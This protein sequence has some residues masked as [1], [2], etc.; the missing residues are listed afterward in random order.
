MISHRLYAAAL[1]AL[2]LSAMP[3]SAQKAQD[4]LR[5]PVQGMEA[6][7]DSYLFPGTFHYIWA[8]SVYDNLLGFNPVKGEFVGQLARSWSQPSPT[9]Y[10]YELREDIKWHDGQPLTADDVVYTIEYLIDPKVNLRNK[11]NWA[12]IQSV[13]KLGPLKVRIV[14]KTPVPEGMMRMAESTHIYPKHVHEP[15]ANKAAFGARPVG[16]GPFKITQFDKN[17]GIIAERNPT[18]VPTAAKARS[19]VGKMIGMPMNDTGSIIAAMLVGQADV[20]VELAPDQV[21]GLVET[22]R[23]E[24]SLGPPGLAHSFLGFPS[25]GAKSVPALGDVRV[26]KAI[27]M[28]IDRRQTFEVQYG[29]LGKTLKPMESLCFKAQLGCG[30]NTTMPAYDPAGAKKLLAEAGYADGFDVDISTYPINVDEVTVVAGM[31]RAVGI[32]ANVRPHPIAQRD[33]MIR[34][35]KIEIGYYGWSGG[36]I[37]DVST[38]ITRHF[39]RNEYDDPVLRQMAAETFTIMDDGARRKAVAK[40]IDH[41]TENAYIFAQIPLRPPITHIKDMQILAKEDLRAVY[42]PSVHEFG[43][44]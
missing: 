2:A 27:A 26:R 13:E 32:R 10:E 5:F 25:A 8:P 42:Q 31:L 1:C 11:S 22:G 20:A 28:A 21:T 35:G 30:Y 36:A 39:L 24:V 40:V 14:A 19:G 29:D 17:A 7:I 18:Y 33:M 4:T 23:F 44:K 43:W 3:A 41:A 16:T 38:T 37:F 34:E 6:G 15:L 12:W 9:T